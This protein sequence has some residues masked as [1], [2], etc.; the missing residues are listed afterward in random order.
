[1]M[2]TWEVTVRDLPID[3]VFNV[4]FLWNLCL[5]VLVPIARCKN[6]KEVSCK[7]SFVP[8]YITLISKHQYK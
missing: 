2:S 1:M 8:A 4:N 7:E 6:T 5:C 3:V